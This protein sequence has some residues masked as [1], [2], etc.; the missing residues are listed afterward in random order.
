MGE[1]LPSIVEPLHTMFVANDGTIQ[2]D[3]LFETEHLAGLSIVDPHCRI[4]TCGNFDAAR[5]QTDTS[6]SAMPLAIAAQTCRPCSKQATASRLASTS[7]MNDPSIHCNIMHYAHALP[8]LSRGNNEVL[9][10]TMD[11]LYDQSTWAHVQKVFA[12]DLV[13]AHCPV[14]QLEKRVLSNTSQCFHCCR[15]CSTSLNSL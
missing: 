5:L 12:K 2:A 3:L 11:E 8:H 10:Y 13:R 1:H 6:L 7:S 15:P 9:H 4:S 14:A